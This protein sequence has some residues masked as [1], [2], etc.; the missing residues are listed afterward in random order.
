MTA[1]GLG[2][3]MFAESVVAHTYHPLLLALTVCLVEGW[4]ALALSYASSMR[5]SAPRKAPRAFTRLRL[6]LLCG[7]GCIGFRIFANCTTQAYRG[8]GKSSALV[9][10]I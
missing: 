8:S 3:T 9:A 2:G 5:N 7:T 4:G 6:K 10:C 1:E